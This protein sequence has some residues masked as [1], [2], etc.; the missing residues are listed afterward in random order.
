[1]YSIAVAASP[2]IRFFSTIRAVAVRCIAIV[3]RSLVRRWLTE[4]VTLA[5]RGPLVVASWIWMVRLRRSIVSRR[6]VVLTRHGLE[7][8][9]LFV[10]HCSRSVVW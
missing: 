9:P 7:I 3:V 5:I 10:R 4:I 1:M 6:T 8:E 2:G